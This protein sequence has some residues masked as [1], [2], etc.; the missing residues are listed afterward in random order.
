MNTNPVVTQFTGDGK[1]FF[2][3]LGAVRRELGG[4]RG[5]V[6]RISQQ[7]G[8]YVKAYLS[9]RAITGVVRGVLDATRA[10]EEAQAQLNSALAAA[11]APVAE[12]SAQLQ[13][14][15]SQ[16]QKTTT[17]GD[18]AIIGVQSLLLSFSHLSGNVVQD[19]SAAVLDIATRMKVDTT[20][21]AR[22][23]GKALSDPIR[24]LTELRTVGVSFTDSQLAQIKA[25]QQSGDLQKAQAIILDEIRQKFGGAAEAAGDTFPGSLKK[26]RNAFGDLLEGKNGLDDAAGSINNLTEILSSPE[27]KDGF[28][29]LISGLATTIGY[30]AKAAAGIAGLAAGVGEFFGELVAGPG[31]LSTERLQERITELEKV[32]QRAIDAQS[33]VILFD[34][35]SGYDQSA[36]IAVSQELVKGY[37]E[38]IAKLQ[39]LLDL[40]REYGDFSSAPATIKTPG[41]VF[42]TGNQAAVEEDANAKATTAF[43]DQMAQDLE[44]FSKQIDD[45]NSEAARVADERIA[46]QVAQLEY[47]Q[48]LRDQDL[49]READYQAER[50]QLAYDTEQ[51]LVQ[52]R[53]DGV[54]AA[55]NLLQAVAG[56]NKAL[57]AAIFLVQKRVAIAEAVIRTKQAVMATYAGLGYPW[58]IPAAAAMA[59]LG[60][61]QIAQMVATNPGTA[62][63]ITGGSTGGGSTFTPG[64]PSNPIFTQQDAGSQQ[65]VTPQTVI[66]VTVNGNT[67]YGMDDFNDVVFEAITEGI[68]NRDMIVIGPNSRQAQ[69]LRNSV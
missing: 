43:Q 54:D 46:D 8:G 16:L 68:N 57:S 33:E 37:D 38:Q 3:E 11:R 51:A 40:R 9:F 10:Q 39:R 24:G 45:V 60:A 4:F 34:K 35:D 61:A 41:V 55:A 12:A 66:H 17:F 64:T 28:A 2:K 7:I 29:V 25:L 6:S 5:D 13:A 49:A 22:T 67:V 27:I 58:G 63:L 62:G 30:A 44:A 20:A 42:T 48:Q 18:E 65:G 23:L 15:A 19:A 59:A 36:R 21:A 56:K 47:Y 52:F 14:Y 50:Q 69:E 53:S 32:R 31:G 26:L 1:P